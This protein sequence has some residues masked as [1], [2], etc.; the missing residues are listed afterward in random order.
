M[1]MSEREGEEQAPP[2]SK[3]GL[4]PLSAGPA[5]APPCSPVVP[6]A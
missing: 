2:G 5:Q 1:H 4:K 6:E 3:A